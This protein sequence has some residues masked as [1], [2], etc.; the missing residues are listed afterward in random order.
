MSLPAT[1][2]RPKA[3]DDRL[4]AELAGRW[5][6]AMILKRDVFSTVERGSFLVDGR[7]VP[8]VLRRIDRVPFWS[9]PI[10][11][12]FLRREARALTI[13]GA[14]G[15]A[16]PLLFEGREALVRGWLDGLPLH[17]AKPHGSAAFFA[18]A[19]EALAALRKHRIAHNDLAKEQNW[20]VGPAGRAYLTDFQLAHVFK[21]KRKAYR[22]LAYE[23]L[24]HLLKHKRKYL[25]ESLTPAEKRVLARKGLPARVWMATGK[26]VYV[27]VSRGIFRFTD[28]E[29]GGPRLVND[30][31]R[32]AATLRAIPGVIDAIVLAYPDRRSG[33]GLYAFVETASPLGEAALRKPLEATRAGAEPPEL[34]QEVAAL[35]RAADGSVRTEIL[36]LIAMNQVDLL[37]PLIRSPE[38]RAVVDR[39]A[40]G[41]VNLRDRFS[42]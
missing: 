38:E 36:Q 18:S 11:Q 27:L 26:K 30:A 1:A 15:F 5:R 19:A 10:A 23:D 17:I 35:P 2:D 28:R 6:P 37:D 7:E 31:P 16:P 9:R 25:A 8:A 14:L 29:G 13:A 32:I 4:P 20:L 41:R 24:R 33:T 42:Y 39:I 34:L 12:H 40:S 22:V 3:D 21:K